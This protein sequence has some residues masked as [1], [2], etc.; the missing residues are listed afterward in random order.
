MKTKEL[1]NHPGMRM[2]EDA[3]IQFD[4]FE[5][6]HG[7]IGVNRAMVSEA[8]QQKFIDRW[9]LGGM[10]NRPPYL[11]EPKQPARDSEHVQGIAFDTSWITHTL[12]YGGDYGFYQRYS[13]DKPHF[14][15]D[16]ARVRVRPST[17]EEA[18][19]QS[20][21]N[22]II[23]IN[24][25][26]MIGTDDGRFEAYET[27]KAENSRGIISKIFFGGDGTTD[28]IPRLSEK[29]FKV[30]KTVWSQMKKDDR[31]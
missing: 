26:L 20:S 17:V 6:D 21:S 22:P 1:A 16:P 3:A 29:D 9:N 13:W 15:F 8:E 23:D 10:Y 11:Y 2:R 30:A 4:L 5:R 19:S 31:K 28:L 7:I 14:E 12:K 18:L 25:T 24:S 27:W